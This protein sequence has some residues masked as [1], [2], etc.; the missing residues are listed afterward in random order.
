MRYEDR[1]TTTVWDSELNLINTFHNDCGYLRGVIHGDKLLY[2]KRTGE[3]KY[4]LDIYWGDNHHHIV[5][6][7]VSVRSRY[8]SSSTH[9]GGMFAVTDHVGRTLDLFTPD[10]RHHRRVGL[11]YITGWGMR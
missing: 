1:N 6:L 7:P 4:R 11:L 5:T 9:P 10:F 2:S 3:D 8:V